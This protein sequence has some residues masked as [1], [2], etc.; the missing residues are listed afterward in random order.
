M[1]L[2]LGW[3]LIL[4]I[5]S[6]YLDQLPTLTVNYA[7]L[8]YAAPLMKKRSDQKLFSE[9]VFAHDLHHSFA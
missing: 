5:V 7:K 6:V 3:G 2:L 4:N 8:K 9:F 1:L